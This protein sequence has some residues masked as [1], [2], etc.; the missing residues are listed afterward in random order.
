MQR[1]VHRAALVAALISL[2]VAFADSAQ[3]LRIGGTLSKCGPN[4][5][6]A[7]QVED[8]LRWWAGFINN[9]GGIV[10]NETAFD[11][12]IVMCAHCFYALLADTFVIAT[13][14]LVTRRYLVR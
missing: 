12:Q 11:V 6:L 3:V 4:A 14:T 7:N 10:I 9:R 1:T 8:S 5:A 13:M 2:Y